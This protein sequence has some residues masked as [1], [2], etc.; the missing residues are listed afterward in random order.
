MA[1]GSY[2]QRKRP[3]GEGYEG[4]EA[5]GRAGDTGGFFR[6]P[7]SEGNVEW[8][9]TRLGRALSR[10]EDD[11]TTGVSPRTAANVAAAIGGAINPV[12]GSGLALYNL[13]KSPDE[14]RSDLPSPTV[15]TTTT[16]DPD[17]NRVNP[18][19]GGAS[20]ITEEHT[21][22]IEE[23]ISARGLHPDSYAAEQYRKES[24]ALAFQTGR[25]VTNVGSAEESTG[26]RGAIWASEVP[27]SMGQALAQNATIWLRGR[28]YAIWRREG[29]WVLVPEEYDE[30]EDR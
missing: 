13:I 20:R 25:G 17:A 14:T 1:N 15:R 9:D 30:R 7:G 12:I 6:R 3:E 10:P 5:Q 23:E 27:S 22:Q 2:T 8:K 29:G 28:K 24:R 26:I 18:N 16:G 21:Q 11:R 4:G 19:D